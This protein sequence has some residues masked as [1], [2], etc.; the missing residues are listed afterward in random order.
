MEFKLSL[1]RVFVAVADTGN[2]QDAADRISRSPSAISMSLKQ[3]EGQCQR[4]TAFDD[5]WSKSYFS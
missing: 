1:L 4:K 3:F 5:N 2:I